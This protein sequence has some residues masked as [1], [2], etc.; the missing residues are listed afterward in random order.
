MTD[1]QAVATM[2]ADWPLDKQ[3]PCTP[4]R[5]VSMM[6]K[7][8]QQNRPY[9]YEVDGKVIGLVNYSYDYSEALLLVITPDERGKGHWTQMDKETA[10]ML[11]PMGIT[12]M[13]FKALDQSS[14]LAD[15]FTKEGEE[16]GETGR[17]HKGRIRADDYKPGGK[18]DK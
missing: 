18:R 17:V 2:L 9:I 14:F 3:G 11:I 16:D 13:K 5:C 6:R 10:D 8:L 15:T 7:W 4:D 12:E 1:W